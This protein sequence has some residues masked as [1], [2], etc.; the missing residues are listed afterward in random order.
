MTYR[1]HQHEIDTITGRFPELRAQEECG[2]P[3][4]K[5]PLRNLLLLC[6][7]AVCIGFAGGLALMGAG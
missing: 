5:R 7:M 1:N 3:M 2:P 4:R 6:F